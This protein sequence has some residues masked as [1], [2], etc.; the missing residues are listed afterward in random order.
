MTSMRDKYVNLLTRQI[1]YPE[2]PL[3][4]NK[5]KYGRWFDVEAWQYFNG[6]KNGQ[7]GWCAE[8]VIWGVAQNEILGKE[9]SKK[10]LGLPA[11]K[12]NAAAG[13]PQFYNYLVA[14]GATF[15]VDPSFICYDGTMQ[16]FVCVQCPSLYYTID[17]TNGGTS[18]SYHNDNLSGVNV[19]SISSGTGAITI[20]NVVD[21]QIFEDVPVTDFYSDI[22]H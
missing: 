12:N 7:C 16:S 8:L 4:S 5:T 22:Q 6:K 20:S 21:S 11:A 1:G 17:T 18:I 2:N 13:C 15:T 3:G 10:F 9:E 19:F 14:N